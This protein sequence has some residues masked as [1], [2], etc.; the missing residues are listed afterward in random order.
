LLGVEGSYYSKYIDTAKTEKKIC[1]VPWDATAKVYTAWD[2]GIGDSTA[3]VFFQVVGNEI[4]IIDCY[5]NNGEG[6]AHYAKVLSEKPYIYE[7]HFAPHDI[8]NRELSTGLSRLQTCKQLGIDFTVLP[9]LEVGIADGI[10]MVRGLFPRFW[11]DVVK[12]KELIKALENYRK[13]YDERHNVF[14]LKPLHDW[15]SHFADS[16]RYL[17]IAVRISL[18]PGSYESALERHREVVESRRK[19]I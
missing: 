5:S 17:S 12:T 3:I 14:K 8:R 15:T 2:I 19:Q 16:I 13:E 9:T 4:H 11:F 18:K 1:S 7:D 10:E 6:F